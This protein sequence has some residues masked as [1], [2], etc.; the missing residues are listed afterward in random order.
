MLAP[1][2]AR[3]ILAAYYW[4]CSVLDMITIAAYLGL[5]NKAFAE[6]ATTDGGAGRALKRPSIN[7]LAVYK[8]GLPG[9]LT[10]KSALYK[11]KL[12]IA[13]DFIHGL[14]LF[15]AVKYVIASN[16]A[17]NPINA[18]R[19]WCSQN[20]LSY[21]ACIDLIKAR[22]E[23]TDQLL[24]AGMD[25]F[26]NE[27]HSLSRSD[28]HGL[29]NTITRIKHCIYDGYRNNLLIK[30]GPDYKTAGGVRVVTPMLF[31]EDERKLA[32]EREYGFVMKV[33]PRVVIYKEL[34][35]KYNR[36]TAIYDVI[37]DRISACDGFLS[38]DPDYAI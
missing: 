32:E 38:I 27:A 13:D 33:L 15:N 1:E 14:I 19:V 16:A 4:D 20:D 10:S 9:F 21:R 31:K 7:W 22:D 25:A 35:L 2:S 23:I 26:I 28:E 8:Q 36:K 6:V 5:D 34:S 29:M 12:L 30:T 17:N 24:G 37:V 18:L 11:I 3:M